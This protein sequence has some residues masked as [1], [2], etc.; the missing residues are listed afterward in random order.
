MIGNAAL[1][2][3]SELLLDRRQIESAQKIVRCSQHIPLAGDPMF[4]DTYIENMLFGDD[5]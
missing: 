5:F 1:S 3:A 4:N 2:G